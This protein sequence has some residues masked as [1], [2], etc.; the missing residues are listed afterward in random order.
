[1]QACGPEG[2]IRPLL[3]IAPVKQTP[4]DKAPERRRCWRRLLYMP[5][6]A[7]GRH[8]T[9]TDAITCPSSEPAAV[10][11]GSTSPQLS[12]QRDPPWR[13]RLPPRR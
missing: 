3:K 4:R 11:P 2:R 7:S 5:S 9:N 6:M 1:M 12:T 8:G 10:N 13:P